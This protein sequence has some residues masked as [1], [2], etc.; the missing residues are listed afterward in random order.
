MI[1]ASR[2]V[3]S[4]TALRVLREFERAGLLTRGMLHT[5]IVL[6]ATTAHGK[7]VLGRRRSIVLP[8]VS[9]AGLVDKLRGGRTD[10]LRVLRHEYAH[11][12]AYTSG[13]AVRRSPAFRRAFGA[14]HDREARALYRKDCPSRYAMENP[15]E[16]FAECV[17][18]Y[19]R[20]NGEVRRFAARPELRR[21]MSFVRSL[22]TKIRGVRLPS[23]YSP[24]TL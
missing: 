11:V 21:K 19:L 24:R 3:A 8:R 7:F 13:Q 6:G 23:N 12:L 16:D 22:R 17:E 2:R 1:F 9:V 20:S 5:P 15:A 10:L 4:Q 14:D 18:L